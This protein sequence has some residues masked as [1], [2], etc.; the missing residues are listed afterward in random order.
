MNGIF[1]NLVLAAGDTPD[2]QIWYIIIVGIL[3][4]FGALYKKY[5]EKQQ[6]GKPGQVPP[7]MRTPPPPAPQP[8]SAPRPTQRQPLPSQPYEV[9]QRPPIAAESDTTPYTPPLYRRPEPL[10][11]ARPTS[12]APLPPRKPAVARPAPVPARVPPGTRLDVTVGTG[13]RSTMQTGLRKPGP[14]PVPVPAAAPGAVQA[15][16]N[17]MLQSPTGL[18]AAFVL[19]EILA[20]PL[21]LRET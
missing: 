21:A 6:T 17:Q 11:T 12:A 10:P 4:A 14:A 19:S 13:P 18:Q 9:A 8:P 7:T 5:Q 1:A 20:P 15:N 3:T 2:A 16:L